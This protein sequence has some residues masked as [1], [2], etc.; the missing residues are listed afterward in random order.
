MFSG[1][2]TQ[3]VTSDWFNQKNE[4]PSTTLVCVI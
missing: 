4:K 2:T 1:H 3:P